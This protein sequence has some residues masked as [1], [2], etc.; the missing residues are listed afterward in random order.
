MVKYS[1]YPG[2]VARQSSFEVEDTIG[3]GCLRGFGRERVD[4]SLHY[5]ILIKYVDI[6]HKLLDV[7]L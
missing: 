5:V 6:M 3:S 2:N 1:Y 7:S 4:V